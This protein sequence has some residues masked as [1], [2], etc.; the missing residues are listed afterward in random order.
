[1]SNEI[2]ARAIEI[3]K[4]HLGTSVDA[5]T[6][7]RVSIGHHFAGVKLSNGGAGACAIPFG[8]DRTETDGDVLAH[9]GRKA[10]ALLR[11]ALGPVGMR[12]CLGIATLSALASQDCVQTFAERLPDTDAPHAANI[13]PEENVVLVGALVPFMR[14][15]HR[16]R[17]AYR[18]LEKDRAAI[19]PD[20]AASFVS[21]DEAA[22]VI[23]TA[24]VLIVTG[25]TLANDTLGGILSLKAP[26]TRIAIVGPTV[27]MVP[28]AFF[29]NGCEIVGGIKVIDADGLLDVIASNGKGFHFFDSS[30]VK[31]TLR[32]VHATSSL[33]RTTGSLA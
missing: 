14:S 28:E 15:L 4:N 1:M 7:T 3:T 31:V 30:A 24:D 33:E 32:A 5:I 19:P 8:Y 27:P 17:I 20:Y 10:T 23:P 11:G 18:V 21:A 26:S 16:R 13:R 22:N 6:V 12:R 2:L 25:S 9:V 29:E